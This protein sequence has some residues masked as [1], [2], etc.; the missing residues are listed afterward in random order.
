MIIKEIIDTL[1]EMREAYDCGDSDFRKWCD[2]PLL[3]IEDSNNSYISD[4]VILERMFDSVRYCKEY[5]DL[6][7]VDFRLQ[8]LLMMS[9]SI[10]MVTVFWDFFNEHKK[11][12]LVLEIGYIM[13]KKETKWK[14]ISMLQPLW[15]SAAY[16]TKDITKL[17]KPK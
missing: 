12:E 15:R 5:L 4:L 3:I 17:H 7:T 9:D 16:S 8:H 1:S 11:V 6:P 14:V 2:L 10:S 13:Q